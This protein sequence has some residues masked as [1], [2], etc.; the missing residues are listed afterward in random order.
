[1]L[2]FSLAS[3]E[4]SARCG[5]RGDACAS[6]KGRNAAVGRWAPTLRAALCFPPDR[7]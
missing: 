4:L 7:V 6:D 3:T 5:P 1:M 2:L